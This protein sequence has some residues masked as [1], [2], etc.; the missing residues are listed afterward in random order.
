MRNYLLLFA[1]LLFAHLA[2][3]Q[4]THTF[5]GRVKTTTNEP[6]LG[7]SVR[8]KNTTEGVITD[9]AGAFSMQ[10]SRP[11]PLTLLVSMIGYETKEVQVT[12]SSAALN[13]YLPEAVEEMSAL[14]VSASR[15]PETLNETPT[16]VTILPQKALQESMI[17]TSNV[18][19]ILSQQV[20]GLAPSTGTS[21]NWG[22]TLR[23]RAML[24][25]VDG[26][27]Q[28]TPLRNGA[29]DMRAL[30]P[31]VIERVE[32]LKGAT[33]VYGNGAAGGLIN[34]ITK[35]PKKANPF[36]SVTELGTTGSFSAIDNSTGTRLSQMI[37][38]KLNRFDYVVSG[39]YEQSGEWKDAEGDVLLPTYGLGETDSYNAFLKLGYNWRPRQRIQLNYNYYSSKQKTNYVADFGNYDEKRKT[40]AVLGDIP[41]VP[42][43]IRANHNLNLRFAGADLP[44]ETSYDIDA[45]FQSVDN[46]FFWSPDFVNGGQ[47]RILSQKKGLRFA[48]NTPLI[49]IPAFASKLTY[50]LDLLND[51]TSQPLVDG[52]IWVPEMNM[53]SFAP[54]TQLK[55]SL[56]E[57]LVFKGGFRLERVNIGVDDYQT[58]EMINRQT[59]G[60][61][62]SFAVKG[63][64]LGYNAYL[65]NAGLRFNK[66]NFFTP[67]ASFSQGFSVADLGV[68]LRSAQVNEL[69]AINTTA[70]IINNYEG[71]FVSKWKEL[72]LEG[73]GYISTSEL[74]TSGRFVDGVFEL[75]RSPEKIW[76]FEA[77]A[78]YRLLENLSIGT[79]YSWVEGK[80]DVNDNG[81]VSDKEDVYLG[82]ER[83]SAPKLTGYVSYSFLDE[84]L[85]LLLQYTGIHG[86][87]RFEQNEK[88]SYDAYKG[89]VEAYDLVNLAACY[90]LNESTSLRLGVENLFNEDYFPARSQWFTLPTMYTKGKGAAFNLSVNISL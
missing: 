14:V 7:V 62:Q 42:Q 71:G 66:T 39:I 43:G 44:A 6:L 27:P 23:G 57:D 30:D 58:M 8:I 34:Y 53:N 48:F 25:M 20:P 81:S 52:R 83:I 76:G 29:M 13:I 60:T 31:T 82:G 87:N 68:M 89:P 86:R 67:Y 32:V 69:S 16:S 51:V 80:L 37:Y 18:I 79:S 45:Y 11:L 77:I 75:M 55:I 3:A 90:K 9:A 63:G 56:W 28:S 17:I 4:K 26:V 2:T 1:L 50:G 19:D 61:T 15:S 38:G 65:F 78:D 70:I 21:S 33:A 40:A 22:Q 85:S 10:T 47:S 12:E 54:F 5:S 41:G 24:I 64:V 74:G 84:R 59:G 72:R 73:V 35:T 46:V 36:S 88:G 49:S